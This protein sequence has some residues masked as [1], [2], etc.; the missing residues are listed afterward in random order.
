MLN[1]TIFVLGNFY[2]LY[3]NLMC[4]QNEHD[5]NGQQHDAREIPD[6]GLSASLQSLTERV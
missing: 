3:I 2:F 4:K 6:L 1:A 5:V